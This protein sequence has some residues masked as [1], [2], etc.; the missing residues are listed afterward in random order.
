VTSGKSSKAIKAGQKMALIGASATSSPTISVHLLLGGT[1]VQLIL[2]GDIAKTI[3][4]DQLID[5]SRELTQIQMDNPNFERF[6]LQ[7]QASAKWSDAVAVILAANG[8]K[9]LPISAKPAL[10]AP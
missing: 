6:T 2:D 5:L 7:A 1:G 8:T 4:L 3:P 10:V 9:D